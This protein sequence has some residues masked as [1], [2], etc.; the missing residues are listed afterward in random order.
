MIYIFDE[1]A[2]NEV[3]ILK[4]ELHKY[5][6]KVRRHK[7]DDK[8][9]FR[10]EDD[11]KKLHTYRVDAIEPK[12]VTLSL[13]DSKVFEI[14]AKKEL[15]IG[16]C[17]VDAKSVE[18]VLPSLSEIGVSKI[19]FIDCKRSQ[20]NI[21]LDFK[22]FDRILHASMQQCGSTQKIEFDTSSSL[23]EFVKQNPD[24]KVFDFV[25]KTL[26]EVKDISTVIIGCEGGFSQ[27]EKEF[28]KSLEVFRLDTPM[29]LRSESAVMA[30]A[31]KVLL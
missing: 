21:K 31:S 30:V 13:Q 17:K 15:H 16:W 8:I 24:A 14:K 25:E 1:N 29:V 5:L 3:L 9:A 12:Q 28:L 4:G 22:R 18:K 6:V 11:I 27:D 19:T 2:G 20:R 23:E 7:V 26:D 10:N